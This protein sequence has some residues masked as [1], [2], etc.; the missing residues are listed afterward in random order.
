MTHDLARTSRALA[1]ELRR[2][3]GRADLP[4]TVDEVIR[5]AEQT[6]G[7][8]LDQL[9]TALQP[10]RQAVADALARIL[11]TAADDDPGQD[12]AVQDQ[13]QR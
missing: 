12:P 1:R 2:D 4:D 9:I 13:L 11:R 6:E 7:V 8:H 10:D 5:V 3:G